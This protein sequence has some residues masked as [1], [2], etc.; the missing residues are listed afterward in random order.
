M[1]AAAPYRGSARSVLLAFKFRGADYLGPR[2]AEVML[3]R[4]GAEAPLYASDEVVAV[5]STRRALRRRGYH[6]AEV[7]AEAVARRLDVRFARRRLRKVRETARQ[8]GLALERRRANVR[9]AFRAAGSPARR[10]LLVDDVATSGWTARECAAVLT[11]AG[12]KEV[13]VWCFARASRDDVDREDEW[14]AMPASRSS[15]V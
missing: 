13:D 9:G 4:L 12:A 11:A 3:A 2:L 10:I 15:S 7:L 8:S 6:P 14:T 5:P 1:R